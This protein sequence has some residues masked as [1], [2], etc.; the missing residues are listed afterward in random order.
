M[1][2]SK[3]RGSSLVKHG[4]RFSTCRISRGEYLVIIY[5]FKQSET[6]AK[7]VETRPV[8]LEAITQN[9]KAGTF[10]WGGAQLSSDGNDGKPFGSVVL[11]NG[12]SVDQVRE[13]ILQDPYVKAQV[14]DPSTVSPRAMI[15]SN[16]ST[17]SL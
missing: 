1:L 11:V 13:S 15:C 16:K 6:L 10:L 5:D 8:H 3:S 12:S 2:R 17:L 7:R 4:Q 9:I 14:W